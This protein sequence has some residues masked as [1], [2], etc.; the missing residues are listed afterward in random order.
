MKDPICGMSV[1]PVSAAAKREYGGQTY[2]FC[3]KGIL[4]Q[5]NM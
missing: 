3:P 4:E 5:W 2:Y 1:D